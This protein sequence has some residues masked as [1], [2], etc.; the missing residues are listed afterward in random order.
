MDKIRS[1]GQSLGVFKFV[2]FIP[3]LS[4]FLTSSLK[5]L[6]LSFYSGLLSRKNVI[7][8]IKPKNIQN[9]AEKSY[10]MKMNKENEI[11]WRKY[12]KTWYYERKTSSLTMVSRGTKCFIDS[13]E[14][15][16]GKKRQNSALRISTWARGASVGNA[17]AFRA[18]FAYNA[19][20]LQINRQ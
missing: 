11:E 4:Y 9:G 6:I 2:Y 15:G 17:I 16:L 8:L 13:W 18:A 12:T 20:D 7:S 10:D 14:T 5:E 3:R 1:N 19:T